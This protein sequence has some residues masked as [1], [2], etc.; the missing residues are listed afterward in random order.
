[1]IR[2]LLFSTLLFTADAACVSGQTSYV[3]LRTIARQG[4]I[5]I[6]R[7]LSR[8]GLARPDSVSWQRIIANQV[9][10]RDI[11]GAADSIRRATSGRQSA[12]GGGVLDDLGDY[13]DD[14][15]SFDA[16]LQRPE[17]RALP[18]YEALADYCNSRLLFVVTS[19]EGTSSRN[20]QTLLARLPRP[21]ACLSLDGEI[22]RYYIFEAWI[23]WYLEL[24][25]SGNAAKAVADIEAIPSGPPRDKLMEGIVNGL[26]ALPPE[27]VETLAATVDDSPSKLR[28][29]ETLVLN[30]ITGGLYGDAARVL[31]EIGNDNL[32]ESLKGLGH[33]LEVAFHLRIAGD[34]ALSDRVLEKIATLVRFQREQVEEKLEE[35]R[36]DVVEAT[37][38]IISGETDLS[39]EGISAARDAFSGFERVDEN[40]AL[41]DSAREEISRFLRLGMQLCIR[42]G[43]PGTALGLLDMFAETMF[44]REAAIQYFMQLST[45]ENSMYLD[46]AMD[47]V[48]EALWRTEPANSRSSAAHDLIANAN[49]ELDDEQIEALYEVGKTGYYRFEIISE[50]IRRKVAAGIDA[51][52]LDHWEQETRKLAIEEGDSPET[53]WHAIIAANCAIGRLEHAFELANNAGLVEYG[54]SFLLSVMTEAGDGGKAATEANET[55]ARLLELLDS[56]PEIGL[57]SILV[58]ASRLP[59]EIAHRIARIAIEQPGRLQTDNCYALS[60]AAQ[61]LDLDI[62]ALERLY[63]RAGSAEYSSYAIDSVRRALKQKPATGIREVASRLKIPW[64][65]SMCETVELER[66]SETDF[67]RAVSM[68]ISEPDPDLKVTRANLLWQAWDAG[69]IFESSERLW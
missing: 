67:V 21:E 5:E 47:R 54:P 58:E 61:C 37:R 57:D 60:L 3:L 18:N 34:E 68:V 28:I 14:W 25:K 30:L 66:Y 2:A 39:M 49:L 6:Q 31:L 15:E 65:F 43:D 26:G 19:R 48:I 11:D 55:A 36:L 41:Y 27:A 38:L 23:N 8:G 17:A 4:L 12:L 1:M 42:R 9:K 10:L 64:L 46:D 16:L 51:S 40:G 53:A 59:P 52:E 13:V 63:S 62:F 35:I 24:V 7:D 33:H 44:E 32:P 56:N 50:L 69:T 22:A 20:A 29:Q 45:S